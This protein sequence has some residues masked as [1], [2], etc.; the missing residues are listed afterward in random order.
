MEEMG[1]QKWR[2][3]DALLFALK[4]DEAT[5]QGCRHLYKLE[6][7]GNQFSPEGSRKN[8][9]RQHLEFCPVRLI[10]DF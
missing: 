10:A 9:P 2:W 6:K 7:A 1:G 4:M 5:S 3:E 8:Q